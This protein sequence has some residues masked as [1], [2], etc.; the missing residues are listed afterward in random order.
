[1][2]RAGEGVGGDGGSPEGDRSAGAGQRWSWPGT[3][4]CGCCELV[5]GLERGVQARQGD[6][7]A[8]TLDAAKRHI[9]ELSMGERAAA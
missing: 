9:G 6:L 3:W 2:G 4:C 7:V 5:A 1:M 8:E